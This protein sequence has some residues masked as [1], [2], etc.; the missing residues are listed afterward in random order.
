MLGWVFEA[1]GRFLDLIS[2]SGSGS[3]IGT[4]VV[5]VFVAVL[6]LLV[7]RFARTVRRDPGSGLE[8]SG[9]V[10]RT[11]REWVADADA[12]LAAGDFREALRC[13][14]RA[15]LAD[16]AAAGLVEEVPGRTTGEYVAA[17]RDD[18]PPALEPFRTATRAFEAAWYGPDPTGPADLEGFLVSA[19]EVLARADV[20]GFAAAGAR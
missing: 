2:G 20:R 9:P 14:Y 8:V 7:F 17:V 6:A 15:L 1:I 18:I 4:V 19:R 10:G 3:L 12:A 16:L 11:A 5:L 13:R